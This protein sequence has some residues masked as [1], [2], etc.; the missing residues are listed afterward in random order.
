MALDL[1]GC[2]TALVTP[3][4][5][6]GTL[7]QPAL[8]RL[9]QFQMREGIDFLVPCGTT[10]ETPTLE[11]GEYL[12]VIHLVVKETRGKVPITVGLGAHNTKQLPL[13]EQKVQG[14]GVHGILS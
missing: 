2:G 13:L 5:R 10:G 1:R 7:D 8:R 3:F 14:L 12:E 9:V 4:T 6:A 11:H